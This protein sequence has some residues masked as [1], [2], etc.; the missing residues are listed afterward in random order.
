MKNLYYRLKSF[1]PQWW[2]SIDPELMW[3][4]FGLIICGVFLA[5]TASPSIAE[6][7][8]QPP[9]A[10]LEKQ[11]I[12]LVPSLFMMMGL[13]ML[14]PRHIRRVCFLAFVFFLI[15]IYRYKNIEIYP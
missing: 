10:L 12:I 14:S 4:L 11:L 15:L 6:Q 13:S 8:N 9:M 5:F 7:R 3:A 2:R 1:L